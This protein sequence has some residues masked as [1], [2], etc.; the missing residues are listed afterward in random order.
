SNPNECYNVFR[1]VKGI[2]FT[3][4]EGQTVRFGQFTSASLKK[5]AAEDFGKDTFF[6][7][8]TCYGVPINPLSYFPDEQEVLIPPFEVFEVIKISH[9][10]G[11]N[12]IE[13]RYK[14][15]KSNHNCELLKRQGR[16]CSW[17]HQEVGLG[18]S[19]ELA[20]PYLSCPRRVRGGSGHREHDPIPAAL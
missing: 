3:A 1:G 5:D 6:V 9:S 4:K 11:N 18:L 16:Q 15:K 20:L 19:P 14:E 7:I 2:R 10:N 12:Q 13:L 17:G 8:N